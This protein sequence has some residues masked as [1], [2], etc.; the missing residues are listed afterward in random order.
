MLLTSSNSEVNSE[1]EHDNPEIET[2]CY[3]IKVKLR[4]FSEK[5]ISSCATLHYVNFSPKQSTLK[6]LSISVSRAGV[7]I[8]VFENNQF[9]VIYKM[10]I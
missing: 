2:N 3:L 4:E 6:Y 1:L 10:T 8:P 5:K 9:S 7:Y